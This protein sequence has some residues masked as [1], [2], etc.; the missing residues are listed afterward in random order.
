V[1]KVG[2]KASERVEKEEI[3]P[4]CRPK[5]A[6]DKVSRF[7]VVDAEGGAGLVVKLVAMAWMREET[8]G[9]SELRFCIPNMAASKLRPDR[10]SVHVVT[11]SVNTR[12]S[13]R[14]SSCSEHLFCR[15]YSTLQ[16]WSAD[17]LSLYATS[18]LDRV[19]KSLRTSGSLLHNF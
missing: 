8:L 14:T 15:L 19:A 7:E 17:M 1:R 16:M 5:N 10:L 9:S 2:V 12:T 11:L 18:L 3:I 13:W 4:T 6:L